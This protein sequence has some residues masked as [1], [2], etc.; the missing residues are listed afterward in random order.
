[1]KKNVEKLRQQYM[2]NLPIGYSK[3]DISR[4]SDE[5]LLDMDYFLNEDIDD[6]FGIPKSST[7]NV[8]AAVLFKCKNCNHTE[9]IPKDVV[10]SLD[11]NFGGPN[12]PPTFSCEKC[13]RGTMFPKNYKSIHGMKY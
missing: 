4:M 5:E 3:N 10:D 7:T 13:C 8:L 2:N 1:M 12:F 9:Y 6:I 11:K